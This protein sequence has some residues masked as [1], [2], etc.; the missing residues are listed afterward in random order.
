[1]HGGVRNGCSSGHC[2]RVGCGWAEWAEELIC[3]TEVIEDGSRV[4]DP[5]GAIGFIDGDE[6]W[7]TPK[8]DS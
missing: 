8:F 3:P 4:V 5:G 7:L 2:W 6:A 1:L